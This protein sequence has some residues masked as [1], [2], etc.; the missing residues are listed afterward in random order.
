MSLNRNYASSRKVSVRRRL[1]AA[2]TVVLAIAILASCSQP[3]SQDTG[4]KQINAENSQGVSD[5]TIKIGVFSV[6][7]GPNAIFSKAA[8]MAIDVYKAKNDAGGINGRMI[9][10]VTV[11]GACDPATTQSQI[12]KLIDQEKVFM[13]H[14]GSCSDVVVA[15]R[16]IIQ[17]TGIPFMSLNATSAA[18]SDPPLINLFHPK[19]TPDEKGT[20]IAKFLAS[21]PDVKKVGLVAA[22]DQLGQDVAAATSTSLKKVDL[23]AVAE[24]ELKNDAGDATAQVQ[25]LLKAG[26]DAI[27]PT[28]QPQGMTSLLRDAYAQGLRVPIV[29]TDIARPDEQLA[30]LSNRGP[31]EMHFGE[32]LFGEPVDSPTYAKF[33]DMLKKSDPKLTFDAFALEGVTSAEMNI[34]ALEAMGDEPTWGKWVDAMETT[35]FETSTSGPISFKKFDSKDPSSRRSKLTTRWTVLDPCTKGSDLIVVNNWDDYVKAKEGC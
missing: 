17:Q 30:R 12:R 29:T 22:P 6:F 15:N 25:Q 26:V 33:R 4:G 28:V 13:I 3:A 23:N 19:P 32:Y 18:I 8:S 1:F 27:S 31:A 10:I 21:D 24:I 11:D 9:E 14:G 34:Q 20:A 16:S 5:D 35:K 2:S 7:S